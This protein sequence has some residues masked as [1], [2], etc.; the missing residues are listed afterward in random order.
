MKDQLQLAGIVGDEGES[1]V[2][3][4]DFGNPQ[5]P[6]DTHILPV[7]GIEMCVHLLG[8]MRALKSSRK[9]TNPS[10]LEPLELIEPGSLYPINAIAAIG[11]H[12]GVSL[13]VIAATTISK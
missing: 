9:A 1:Q 4:E 10:R 11:G 2:F 5:P 7:Q 3:A 8:A 13:T 12:T 6:G